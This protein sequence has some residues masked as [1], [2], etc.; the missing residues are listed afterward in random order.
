MSVK[1]DLAK[2]AEAL[3]QFDC[4]YLLSVSQDG[5]V[6]VVSVEARVEDGLLIASA[7]GKGTAANI[8]TNRCVT[9]LFAPRELHGMS[10]IVDG[11]ARLSEPDVLIEPE[12][13]VLH[14]PAAHSPAPSA[15]GDCANDCQP[16][17]EH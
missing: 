7:P 15:P 13:A 16:L 12:F 3:E 6:K 2:L 17:G 14:R 1:V 9:V 4:G 11:L 8:A 10:L 5:R